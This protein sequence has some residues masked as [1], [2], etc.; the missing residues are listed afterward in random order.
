M[1][2][3]SASEQFPITVSLVD[4]VDGT[5]G[6][7]RSVFY[8][9]RIHPNDA[10][11]NPPVSGTLV[12][13][14]TQSGVYSKIFSLPAAG[15]Y[16]VYTYCTGFSAGAENII[17][18]E[19]NLADLVKQNRHFNISVEDVIRENSVATASQTTRKVAVGNT[20]Y[21]ITRIKPNSA[22]DWTD[23]ATVSGIV[24]AHYRDESEEVPFLMGGPE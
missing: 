17:V 1:I 6:S 23:S 2:R 18:D 22:S 14:T 5:M 20:D 24:Y 4:E 19:D 11:L 21:V 12:E 15:E 8:D 16:I 10:P 9:M 7:G 13:S 3:V